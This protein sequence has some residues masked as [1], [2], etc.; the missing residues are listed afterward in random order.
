M[1]SEDIKP[2]Q[3][4]GQAAQF[5]LESKFETL[6]VIWQSLLRLFQK[7][8]KGKLLGP[9]GRSPALLAA[10]QSRKMQW[11]EKLSKKLI[12]IACKCLLSVFTSF[13][14]GNLRFEWIFFFKSTP[15]SCFVLLGTHQWCQI[16][17]DMFFFSMLCVAKPFKNVSS[18]YILAGSPV[19]TKPIW[20]SPLDGLTAFKFRVGLWSLLV[21][22]QCDLSPAWI[23]SYLLQRVWKGPS[24]CGVAQ[25]MGLGRVGLASTNTGCFLV[26][27][28]RWGP[29]Q[30]HLRKTCYHSYTDSVQEP[31]RFCFVNF[32]QWLVTFIFHVEWNFHGIS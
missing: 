18:S 1:I 6:P 13:G 19:I 22:C 27:S 9:A 24:V 29:R 5:K 20:Q 8:I 12:K 14:T 17:H 10:E 23:N 15:D 31:I 3:L 25:A 7:V 21:S 32:G 4:V 11:L 2:L 26:G 28:S 30:A 16:L